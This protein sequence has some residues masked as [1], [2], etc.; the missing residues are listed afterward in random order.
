LFLELALANPIN[1]QLSRRLASLGLP[2]CHL[3]AGCLY[4]AVWNAISGHPPSFGIKDYDVF[5]FDAGDLSWE[6]EDAV[7]RRVDAATRDL[8]V[9]VEVKNQARVHLWY[10]QRFGRAQPPLTSARESIESYL[11]ACTCIGLDVTT[12]RLHAPFGFEDLAA[13]LLRKNP[14]RDVPDDLFRRKAQSYRERWP[15]LRI[16]D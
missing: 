11:V 15:W 2:Q 5:Y 4:Q 16:D 14:R 9:E 8:G 6:A 12:G 3:V 13:G 7:I 10:E 1:A